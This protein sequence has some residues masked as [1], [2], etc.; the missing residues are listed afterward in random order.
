M[1]ARLAGFPLPRSAWNDAHASQS[2]GVRA[3]HLARGRVLKDGHDAL[4]LAQLLLDRRVR[5]PQLDERG[6]ALRAV[7]AAAARL[8]VE[9]VGPVHERVL[10]DLAHRRGVDRRAALRLGVGALERLVRLA[11]TSP[12][13]NDDM[14][15]LERRAGGSAAS[16]GSHRAGNKNGERA[17]D[18][19]KFGAYARARIC[20]AGR[21]GARGPMRPSLGLVVFLHLW[22]PGAWAR[23]KRRSRGAESITFG[24]RDIEPLDDP[25]LEEQR[26]ELDR[27]S[28]EREMWFTA[29]TSSQFGV[30]RARA[31]RPRA[32]VL[33]PR[34]IARARARGRRPKAAAA[35][36]KSALRHAP[37]LTPPPAAAAAARA[38]QMLETYAERRGRA[39]SDAV[40]PELGTVAAVPGAES[41]CLPLFCV[42]D[43][44][45]V[46]PHDT[47]SRRCAPPPPRPRPA[48]SPR[49]FHRPP[50]SP[51]GTRAG[52][53]RERPRARRDGT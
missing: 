25:A 51:A 34:P 18:L 37:S 50:P 19:R 20:R 41:A 8:V 44:R 15:N 53:G 49:P 45:R 5:D 52:E 13:S 9:L 26:R 12:T 28:E 14:E 40:E 29:A 3:R 46:S 32:R 36:A 35:R 48:M 10:V 22:A 42:F 39:C 11:R 47:R 17:T 31:A 6:L 27:Q 33:P 38:P 23:R 21:G 30:V 7:A 1:Y 4:P 24:I 2:A 16:L 43:G